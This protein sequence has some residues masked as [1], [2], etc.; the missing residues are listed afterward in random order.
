MA[1][2]VAGLYG[3]AALASVVSGGPLDPPG[4]PLAGT[5]QTID[6]I[7]P[8]WFRLLPSND[9]PDACNS[10]RFKCVM[11]GGAAVLD[12]ETG[13]VWVRAPAA[14]GPPGSCRWANA[15]TRCVKDT[16]GGRKGWRLPHVEEL[17]SLVD[18][19]TN[20]LPA[21]HPF[22][23]ANGEYWTA[24]T[25]PFDAADATDLEVIGGAAF[26]S[27]ISKTTVDANSWCVRGGH[28]DDA[29]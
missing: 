25:S 22:T 9:G 2:G 19:A 11:D 13:L 28:N 8:S 7:P 24:S 27:A 14:C 10:A 4:P 20:A 16:T 15:I 6:S 12:L 26:V 3:A 29:P 17:Q 23:V 5:M 21:G 1:L 18:P